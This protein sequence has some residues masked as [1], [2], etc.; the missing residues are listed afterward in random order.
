[1]EEEMEKYGYVPDENKNFD[2]ILSLF[3]GKDESPEEIRKKLREDPDYAEHFS[4]IKQQQYLHMM[5]D[6]LNL[7]L[8]D[9]LY[10]EYGFRS[11]KLL[12]KNEMSEIIE[13]YVSDYEEA[14]DQ[15]KYEGDLF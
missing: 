11:T 12:F 8:K 9:Y 10:K 3:D 15:R 14:M 5:F 13:D 2:E 6:K 7:D 4:T 1:M